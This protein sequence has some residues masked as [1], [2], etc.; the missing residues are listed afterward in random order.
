MA[1]CGRREHY[2]WFRALRNRRIK[3]P[4]VL[5]R[6]RG[7]PQISCFLHAPAA[8]DCRRAR[9]VDRRAAPAPPVTAALSVALDSG[10]H[11]GE[12]FEVVVLGRRR[13]GTPMR[14]RENLS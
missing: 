2:S 11:R 7:T 8:T 12:N 4:L 13:S 5:L 10:R 14:A 1:S 9:V 3:K 6:N